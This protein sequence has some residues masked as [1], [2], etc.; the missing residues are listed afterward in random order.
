MSSLMSRRHKAVGQVPES[1][2]PQF[3]PSKGSPE[4]HVVGDFQ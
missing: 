3:D 4:H 2:S 1:E